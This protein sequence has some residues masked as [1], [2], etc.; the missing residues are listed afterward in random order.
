MP[1]DG[2]DG[3]ADRR[4]PRSLSQD[5]QALNPNPAFRYS[6]WHSNKEMRIAGLRGSDKAT[7]GLSNHVLGGRFQ[8]KALDQLITKM[9]EM[10]PVK[11]CICLSLK[12]NVASLQLPPHKDQSLARD[13]R[14]SSLSRST[15]IER[16]ER[17]D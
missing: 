17:R 3:N 12:A 14:A 8:P 5:L 9:N 4:R 1:A 6:L 13:K 2:F 10:K 7:A 11:S 15:T 16:R